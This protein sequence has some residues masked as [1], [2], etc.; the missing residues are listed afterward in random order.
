MFIIRNNIP[1]AAG[2]N[3]YIITNKFAKV[4]AKVAKTYNM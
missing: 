2:I 3:T 1:N 4:F